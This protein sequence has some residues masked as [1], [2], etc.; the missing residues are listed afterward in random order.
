MPIDDGDKNNDKFKINTKFNKKEELSYFNFVGK[1]IGCAIRSDININFNITSIFWKSI[2]GE[3][4]TLE[5][6]F[7][8]NPSF[9]KFYSSLKN[10]S[11]IVNNN[12]NN[13]NN[14]NENNHI[15]NTIDTVHTLIDN[16]SSSDTPT[17]SQEI[18]FSDSFP[19]LFFSVTDSNNQIVDLCENGFYYLFF[20]Y[21][22]F[23]LFYFFFCFNFYYF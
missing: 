5:D 8:I 22:N 1:L 4:V 7:L 23:L 6:L 12:N 16:H 19:S 13:E 3:E 17:S 18:L 10:F 15:I 14:I 2:T 20:N 11:V 9:Q 21:F